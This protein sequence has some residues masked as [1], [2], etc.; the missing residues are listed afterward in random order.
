[1]QFSKFHL[2]IGIL[3]SRRFFDWDG[4]LVTTHNVIDKIA[5]KRFIELWFSV[6]DQQVNKFVT[7]R[8]KSQLH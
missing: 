8:P 6:A 5:T 1:M 7:C 4:L 2:D 3:T